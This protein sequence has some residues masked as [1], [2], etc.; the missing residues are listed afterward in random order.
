MK[1]PKRVPVGPVIVVN[2]SVVRLVVL[3]YLVVDFVVFCWHALCCCLCFV[4]D[5]YLY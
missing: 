1:G 3:F 2:D 4:V 5:L